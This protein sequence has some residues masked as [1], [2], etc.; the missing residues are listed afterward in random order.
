M[1]IAPPPPARP[2]VTFHSQEHHCS[3]FALVSTKHDFHSSDQEAK[4]NL[5]LV[6]G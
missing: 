4:G 2:K 1:Q 5:V 3:V 6:A